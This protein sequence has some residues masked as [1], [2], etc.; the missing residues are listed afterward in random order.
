MQQ[1]IPALSKGDRV[2]F[3]HIDEGFMPIILSGS[4]IGVNHT[5]AAV[6]LL[7]DQIVVVE[8]HLLRRPARLKAQNETL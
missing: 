7:D 1:K 5:H 4:V 3:S 6:R 8:T 2:Y